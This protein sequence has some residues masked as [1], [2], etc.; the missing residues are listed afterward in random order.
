MTEPP[1]VVLDPCPRP[2][3]SMRHALLVLCMSLAK[4][5]A[6]LWAT[7]LDYHAKPLPFGFRIAN[8]VAEPYV[9]SFKLATT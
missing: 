6:H 5:A 8:E 7:Y 2:G 3:A 1:S 9:W 4:T